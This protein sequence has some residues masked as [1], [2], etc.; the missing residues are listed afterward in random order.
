MSAV[1]AG[2]AARADWQFLGKDGFEVPAGG[3][4]YIRKGRTARQEVY[5]STI[6]KHILQDSL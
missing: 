3:S 2:A 6:P 4:F 1:Q 5:L